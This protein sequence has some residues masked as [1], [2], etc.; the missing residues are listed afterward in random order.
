VS[1]EEAARPE[2]AA[3]VP[4][5][6]G[7]HSFSAVGTYLVGG[8]AVCYNNMDR[9][10]LRE[11][12]LGVVAAQRR[13]SRRDTSSILRWIA[14]WL[15]PLLLFAMRK[16]LEDLPESLAVWIAAG[17]VQHFFLVGSPNPAASPYFDP[18]QRLRHRD[19]RRGV[20]EGR[21]Y[22]VLNEADRGRRREQDELLEQLFA[23]IEA[24]NHAYGNRV[25]EEGWSERF[26]ARIAPVSQ[27]ELGFRLYRTG[28]LR[29]ELLRQ[30]GRG[31]EADV[32]AE[33]FS[34]HAY[35]FVRDCA[36]RHYH[37]K[38]TDDQLLPAIRIDLYGHAEG[39]T[40][41]RREVLWALTR[42]AGQ[43][44]RENYLSAR[45]QSLGVLAY[46]DAFQATL[47]RVRR[48]DDRPEHHFVDPSL[49]SF[50]F[51]HQKASTQV[52]NDV[53]IW[54][55][56]GAWAAVGFG[57]ATLL[58]LLGIWATVGR[59]AASGDWTPSPGALWVIEIFY[60]NPFPFVA[61]ALGFIW[62]L[63]DATY[64]DRSA[65]EFLFR[66]VLA[67]SWPSKQPGIR[68]Q[69]RLYWA[70]FGLAIIILLI[71]DFVLQIRL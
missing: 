43:Y 18:E 51:G 50:D 48:R 3:W 4:T 54:W 5:S 1:E 12:L 69:R 71:L 67:I 26:A 29:L 27:V 65:Y 40:V 32:E 20:L 14:R 10:T 41:W 15:G 59:L 42:T 8:D 49:A 19:D 70:T 21:V 30:P 35:Y 31:A 28:E 55:R 25:P 36:H 17:Y 16:R 7:H 61:A 57:F 6:S 58:S 33:I 11:S 53:T 60:T 62:V 37:H 13:I 9:R 23:D 45:R 2:Y 39:E 47:A 38:Q 34:R 66:T 44:R 22:I 64:G 46:A 56:Q 63:W 68:A 24:A 52:A